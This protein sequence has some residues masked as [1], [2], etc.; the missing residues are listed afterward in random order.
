MKACS[1]TSPSW[2]RLKTPDIQLLSNTTWSSLKSYFANHKVV[3]DFIKQ[4]K[5]WIS[6][7]TNCGWRRQ[8]GQLV[9]EPKEPHALESQSERSDSLLPISSR[10]LCSRELWKQ[11]QK[12]ARFNYSASSFIKATN[13]TQPLGGDVCTPVEL[14]LRAKVPNR[15]PQN[16]ITPHLTLQR[17]ECNTEEH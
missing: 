9:G 17:R 10:C 12:E 11:R 5:W 16:V 8:N 13:R 1:V 7:H 2:I 3:K 4:F 14:R 6:L 15:D